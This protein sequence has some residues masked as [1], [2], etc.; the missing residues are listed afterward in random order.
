MPSTH[1]RLRF[2]LWGADLDPEK[3]TTATGV[4][5]S[6]SFHV[7]E[8]RGRAANPVAGWEWESQWGPDDEPL[9]DDILRV[10]GP[11]AAT[12]RAEVDKG[13]EAHLSISGEVYGSVVATPVEAE[14]RSLYVPEDRPFEEFL[15]CDR[16]ALFLRPEVVEFLAAI[17][18]SLGT[19]IDAELDPDS[20]RQATDPECDRIKPSQADGDGGN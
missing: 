2:W 14:R 9:F 20:A 8:R 18:A 7:G 10:L 3:L 17:H 15:Y 6:R 4:I 19:H 11:H 5:P 1:V 13:A 16:V 12:L